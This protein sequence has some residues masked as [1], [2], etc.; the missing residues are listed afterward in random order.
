MYT[1]TTLNSMQAHSEQINPDFI[2]H[3]NR[4][5]QSRPP[6]DIPWYSDDEELS[7]RASKYFSELFALY[8]EREDTESPAVGNSYAASQTAKAS[9]TTLF[10]QTIGHK[11]SLASA[12]VVQHQPKRDDAMRGQNQT[13]FKKHYQKAKEIYQNGPPGEAQLFWE[14]IKSYLKERDNGEVLEICPPVQ[15]NVAV[16]QP[17]T[18]ASRPLPSRAQKIADVTD[19]RRAQHD[20]AV[21]Y[22]NISLTSCEVPIKFQ[23]TVLT[24]D[25]NK[26]LPPAPP[27]ST[28]PKRGPQKVKEKAAHVLVDE[29][30]NF[31]QTP[32]NVDMHSKAKSKP[33]KQEK[34]HNA[35]KAKISRPIPISDPVSC[36]PTLPRSYPSLSEKAKGK[37]KVPS[38]PAWLNKL[39]HP[40]LP[41]TFKGAKRTDSDDSF[42]CQGIDEQIDYSTY[43][44]DG[45]LSVQEGGPR[46]R[47]GENSGGM[48]RPA[49]L[50]TRK[51]DD[52]YHDVDNQWSDQKTTASDYFVAASNGRKVVHAVDRDNVTREIRGSTQMSHLA[53]KVRWQSGRYRHRFIAMFLGWNNMHMDGWL[54]AIEKC[55]R[56]GDCLP[57]PI[58]RAA[59]YAKCDHALQVQ[60]GRLQRAVEDASTLTFHAR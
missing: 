2:D 35:L 41:A 5:D 34:A 50:L 43:I 32:S 44:G 6:S 21:S 30:T 59:Q 8:T 54:V 12:D 52:S 22:S 25:L 23:Q 46:M 16:Q 11:K 13:F 37:Q 42:I 26:P 36:S 1:I 20:S 7:P 47:T 38:S 56:E 60:R 55:F 49:A 19:K 17:P 40:A 24:V 58:P 4:T 14:G 57:C 9:T 28:A 29:R 3:Q 33:S 45:V 51:K 10:P 15:K 48:L 39:A 18:S 31:V 27:L 53:S